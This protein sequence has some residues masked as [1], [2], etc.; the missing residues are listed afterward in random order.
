MRAKISG[1]SIDDMKLF[2][3]NPLFWTTL[4]HGER[5][6]FIDA[7]GLGH[8]QPGIRRTAWLLVLDLLQG[9][10]GKYPAIELVIL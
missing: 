3:S 4:H 1:S 7:E 10:K 2:F 5:P 9:W 6:P 8:Q